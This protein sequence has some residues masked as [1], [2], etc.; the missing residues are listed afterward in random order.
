MVTT[1]RPAA[2]SRRSSSPGG[3]NSKQPIEL[4]IASSSSLTMPVIV[5][6][7]VK[8]SPP[9]ATTCAQSANTAARPGIWLSA[10]MQTTASNELPA[11]GSR[12]PASTLAKRALASRFVR[13]RSA[14]RVEAALL[15]VDARDVAAGHLREVHGEASRAAGMSSSRSP[16]ELQLGG[17]ALELVA[18]LPVVL[19]EILAK[20]RCA[21]LAVGAV[22]EVA[23]HLPV[24]G[25]L[26]GMLG[27]GASEK[28][29]SKRS[30]ASSKR[31]TSSYGRATSMAPSS[32]LTIGEPLRVEAVERASRR[33]TR[34]R[35]PRQPGLVV[36]EE[37]Q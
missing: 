24:P 6:G 5:T 10:S 4:L 14:A 36:V 34:D 32:P 12:R 17:E 18:R 3:A 22:G 9:P 27:H 21:D 16:R 19:S 8:R 33:A 2:A 26:C 23:V 1:S 11:K 30:A 13:A 28:P 15:E 29:A 35:G 7:S 25:G 31:S 20:L 37:T